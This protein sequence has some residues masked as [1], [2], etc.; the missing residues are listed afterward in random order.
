MRKSKKD[1]PAPE[2]LETLE[3]HLAGT[4]RPV[5]PPRNFVHRLGRRIHIPERRAIVNRLQDW[6]RL[7]LVLGSVMSGMVLVITLARALYYMTGR[8][9]MA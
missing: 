5:A 7:F 3:A 1:S 8:R 4:L 2:T 6:K 9:R